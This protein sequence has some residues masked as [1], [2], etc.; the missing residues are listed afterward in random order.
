MGGRFLVDESL[1][2]IIADAL[3][4]WGFEVFEVRQL[5]LWGADDMVIYA[6]AQNF[7]ATLITADKDFG[8]VRRFPLGIH[9][10]I[11]VLRVIGSPKRQLKALRRAL[12]SDLKGQ[13]LG[14]VLVIVTE[15]KMRLRKS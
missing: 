2:P 7:A 6:T 9:H 10:G 4:N 12:M 15:R 3:R 13:E 14:G 8:D 1:S 11:I 5:G